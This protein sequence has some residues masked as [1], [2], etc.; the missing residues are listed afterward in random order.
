MRHPLRFVGTVLLLF[1]VT[2]C[3]LITIPAGERAA[4]EGVEATVAQLPRPKEFDWLQVL[5][6]QDHMTVQGETCYYGTAYVFLGTSL[7]TS[8][9]FGAYIEQLRLLGWTPKS[10]YNEDLAIWYHGTNDRLV[11]VSGPAEELS[12]KLMEGSG[13]TQFK[14]IYPTV[15]VLRV[16][17]MLPAREEC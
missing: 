1:V 4:R 12:L 16:T 3:S 13:Y 5:Y 14:K 11:F 8:I 10:K 7:P 6:Y 17:Y 2:S 9:A 15:I